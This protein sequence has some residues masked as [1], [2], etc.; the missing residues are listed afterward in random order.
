MKH[1]GDS[2]KSGDDVLDGAEPDPGD[3]VRKEQVDA[4][5]AEAGRVEQRVPTLI[6]PTA[7]LGPNAKSHRFKSDIPARVHADC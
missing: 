3:A 4:S 1:R 2:G 5:D 7:K 6:R